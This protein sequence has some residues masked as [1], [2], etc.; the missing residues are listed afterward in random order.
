MEERR[1]CSHCCHPRSR[2]APQGMAAVVKPFLCLAILTIKT[3]LLQQICVLS[4]LNAVRLC[5]VHSGCGE[6]SLFP[7]SLQML[8]YHVSFR[9]SVNTACL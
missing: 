7:F 5:S 2:A 8:F 9:F 4:Q 6:E 3:F 1:L